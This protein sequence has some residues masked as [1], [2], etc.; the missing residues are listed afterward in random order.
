MRGSRKK[1][2]TQKGVRKENTISPKRFTVVLENIMRILDRQ[3]RGVN[4]D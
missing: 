4:I 1:I 3:D 2:E